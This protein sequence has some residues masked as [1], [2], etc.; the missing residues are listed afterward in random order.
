MCAGLWLMARSFGVRGTILILIGI[1]ISYN[2]LTG[3][4]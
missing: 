3:N 1:A 4:V 2:L